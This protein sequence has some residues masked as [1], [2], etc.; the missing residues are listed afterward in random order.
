MTIEAGMVAKSV[1]GSDLVKT[2][3]YGSDP[4]WGRVM[5]AIGKSGMQLDPDKN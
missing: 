5:M 4:N 1:V 2:M 3:V